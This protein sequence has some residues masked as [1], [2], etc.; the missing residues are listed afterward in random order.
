M[1][2]FVVRISQKVTNEFS[3]ISAWV[4]HGPW[5]NRLDFGDADSFMECGSFSRFFSSTRYSMNCFLQY[6]EE[7][8]AWNLMKYTLTA[9]IG[10]MVWNNPRNVEEHYSIIYS[11]CKLTR[12]K[13][14]ILFVKCT[15]E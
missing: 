1:S 9:N 7:T 10:N 13:F 6:I 14:I 5:K 8:S 11:S 2:V 4:G 15:G 12:Q 3:K